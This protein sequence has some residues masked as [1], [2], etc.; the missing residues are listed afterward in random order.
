MLQ[1]FF[2]GTPAMVTFAMPADLYW[3]SL[4]RHRPDVEQKSLLQPETASSLRPD[5]SLLRP[6][7]SLDKTLQTRVGKT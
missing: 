4:D 7:D 5:N 2:D 3:S 6:E 1:Q